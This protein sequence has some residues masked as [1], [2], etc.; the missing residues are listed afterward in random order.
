MTAT[1]EHGWWSE[2]DDQVLSCL[3]EGPTSTCDLARRL[4][5]SP[6][7]ATSVLLML[8]AEGKIRVTAVELAE[9]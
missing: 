5:L 6:G 9:T 1:A 2:L 7:G 3:R 8:A 4:N